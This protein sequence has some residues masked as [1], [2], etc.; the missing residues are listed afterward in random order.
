M[1]CII[2]VTDFSIHLIFKFKQ[3]KKVNITNNV[4]WQ[5]NSISRNNETY[6]RTQTQ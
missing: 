5:E 6:G 1:F 4:F 2:E 3:C